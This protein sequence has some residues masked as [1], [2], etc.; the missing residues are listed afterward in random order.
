MRLRLAACLAA[1]QVVLSH[2][3]LA[4]EVPA[5]P[6]DAASTGAE[7][8]P[9][10]PLL[11][12]CVREAAPEVAALACTTAIDSRQLQGEALA[13]ALYTRGMAQGR[14]GQMAAAINDFTAALS[15]APKATDALFARASAQAALGRHDLAIAD[16][17]AIL[18]ID[19]ADTD[20]LYRRA[21]S[22]TMLGRDRDAI[23]DLTAV[24]TAIPNDIDALM[25][26]GGLNLRS[27]DFKA[28][29]AD[30]TAIIKSDPTA[31]AAFYNRGRAFALQNNFAGA[32]KDF[33]VA[34][35]AREDNPYAALRNYLATMASGKEE[36]NLLTEAIGRFPPDQWPLP[37]L[38][39][40]AGQISADDLLASAAAADSHVK[41]RLGAEAH[42]YL[43]EAALTTGDKKAARAHFE[44]AAKG[45]RTVPEVIDAGWRLKQLG[46]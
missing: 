28:A 2:G 42:F 26:R 14:R 17:N 43:G 41:Q 19:P 4:D 7:A 46:G 35:K 21:W 27:G 40:L 8:P 25:D 3:A 30:F 13:T 16:Y 29:I 44:A 12:E 45:E 6:A 5:E 31:A 37:V 39:T 11:I 36:K 24:L 18:K 23:A 34:A 32:A 38:A 9:L 10:N 20:S 1:F 15:L 33:A 22:Y